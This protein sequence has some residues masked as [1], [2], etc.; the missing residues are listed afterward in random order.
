MPYR[1][2][3]LPALRAF[4]A[5][6]RHLSFKKAAEEL[7]VT[8]AAVSQQIRQLEEYLGVVLFRRLTR[9][10]ELTAP[11]AAMLPALRRGFDCIASAVDATRDGGDGPLTVHAPPSFA[12]RWLVPRLPR[13]AAVAPDVAL[14]LASDDDHVDREGER[15]GHEP[16]PIDPRSAGSEIAIRYGRGIYPG[17][18]VDKIFAPEYVPV[19]SPRLLA[20]VHP[21]REPADLRHQVL[22]HDGTIADEDLQPGWAQWLAAV[23]VSG[24]DAGRGLRFSNAVLAVEAALDGQGVALALSPL[25]EAE[26]AAGRLLRPFAQAIPSPYAYWLVMPEMLAARPA[27][28]AFSDW[29][30]AE[31]RRISSPS[32]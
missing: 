1:L 14:H 4:E 25:V 6:A 29:I 20:G 3:P 19:C 27:V 22:I 12:S 21:L 9:A 11:G 17:L 2:P 30:L 26:I 15:S 16:T 31:G 7:H 23:G 18:R 28:R 10:I 5:A 13:L 24:V 32:K 8:P